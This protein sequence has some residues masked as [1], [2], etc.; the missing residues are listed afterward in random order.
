MKEKF[1]PGYA[2]CYEDGRYLMSLELDGSFK[3]YNFTSLLCEALWF[4]DKDSCQAICTFL[5]SVDSIHKYRIIEMYKNV[6]F[7]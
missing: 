6:R 3:R 5:N 2:C 7:I 1:I 4:E